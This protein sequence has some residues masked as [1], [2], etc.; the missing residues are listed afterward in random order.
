MSNDIPLDIAAFTIPGKVF[1]AMRDFNQL[2]KPPAKWNPGLVKIA[3]HE[4]LHQYGWRN[5]LPNDD[6]YRWI[7]EGTVESVTQDFGS[8]WIWYA[9]R[10]HAAVGTAYRQWSN[11]IRHASAKATGKWWRSAQAKRWRI[12]LL[13]TPPTQRQS[14]IP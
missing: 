12:K 14:M 11:T 7:E 2:S 3:L 5:G 6:Q 13:L 10:Q 9:S 4:V 8:S 1:F